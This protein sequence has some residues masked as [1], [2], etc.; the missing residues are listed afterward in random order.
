[1]AIKDVLLTLT[2]YPEPSLD[3]IIDKAIDF[4]AAIEAKLSAVACEVRVQMPGSPLGNV[5]LDIQALAD[6]EAKK[7]RGSAEQLL[8][9]FEQ[10]ATARGVFRERFLD[11]CLTSELGGRLAG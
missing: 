2:S 11:T 3:V 4:V 9:T 6:R 8:S 5:L 7:S 1:M 10:K